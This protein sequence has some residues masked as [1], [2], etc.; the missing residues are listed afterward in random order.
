MPKGI[1]IASLLL[2]LRA[3]KTDSRI[4]EKQYV[5]TIAAQNIQD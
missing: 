4:G 5:L 3:G 1:I 2:K